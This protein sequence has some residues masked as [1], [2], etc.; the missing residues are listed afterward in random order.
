MNKG[1]LLL[2]FLCIWSFFTSAQDS[3]EPLSLPFWDDFSNA[4]GTP[5]SDLW[6]TG[7]DI[8]VNNPLAI[9]AP[10]INVATFDGANAFGIP[11][12]IVPESQ[13]AADSLISRPIDLASASNR[14]SVF[15]SFFWQVKGY[16]EIP[17][18]TDSIRLQLLDRDGVWQTVWSLTGG[19]S[20]V[21]EE[22]TFESI[23]IT[24][25]EY[26]HNN[27][28][29]KFQ[30][31]SSLSGIFDTWHID[32]VYLNENRATTRTLDRSVY[33]NPGPLFGPYY[34][35]PSTGIPAAITTVQRTT[36]NNLDNTVHPVDYQHT[37]T[38]LNTGDIIASRQFI[39]SI[40]LPNETRS[41]IGISSIELPEIIEGDSIVI[42]SEFFYKT[43]DRNLFEE[44][45]PNGDTVFLDI[46]LTRN[47][48]V[49]SNYLIH[50][51]YAYDDGSAEFA[52]GLNL[53]QGQLAI[54][55]VTAT[56]DTLSHIEVY[57]PAF[58]ESDGQPLD[59]IVWRDLEENGE[60]TRQSYTVT[61]PNGR[62]DFDQVSLFPPVIVSDTFYIGYQQFTDQYIGLGL[63]KSNDV[64]DRAFFN[65]DRT[66]QQNTLIQGALM[67]RPVFSNVDALVLSTA[68]KARS[69]KIYP[70]PSSGWVHFESPFDEVVV[71]DLA[72]KILER[73]YEGSRIDLRHL[74]KGIYLLKIRRNQR[75][76]T[77]K[78]ILKKYGD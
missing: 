4:N 55:F 37:I 9:N 3:S 2:C 56:Q 70:N 32:Y 10:S 72:G 5:D 60:L 69:E 76:T 58:P 68:S 52:A 67:I 41:V 14:S 62:N 74:Q 78:L 1:G 46:D 73:S 50:D 44:V 12:N 30:S 71:M 33:M 23:Q 15:L 34:Q 16:G 26:F 19:P 36:L 28:K 45:S 66:W 61:T 13:G 29:M 11:H 38:N 39:S 57:F 77:Q 48:T 40:L 17:E 63:D 21:I 8:Y 54:Q 31:F 53:D 35:I 51:R 49:R 64:G 18:S 22:F 27:F 75:V 59:L 6:E 65:A 47:D 7:V 42:Q 24:D 25:P 43:G 20:N